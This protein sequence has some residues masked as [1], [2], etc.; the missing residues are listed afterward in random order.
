MRKRRVLVRVCGHR[1]RKPQ[2]KRPRGRNLAII[3]AISMQN[4]HLHPPHGGGGWGAGFSLEFFLFFA[5]KYMPATGHGTCSPGRALC[6]KVKRPWGRNLAIMRSA[7]R[8]NEREMPR[9]GRPQG[10]FVSKILLELSHGILSLFELGLRLTHPRLH[11]EVQ[12]GINIKTSNN[13]LASTVAGLAA[14]SATSSS[15]MARS[16]AAGNADRRPRR[17][18]LGTQSS[19]SALFFWPSA[20]NAFCKAHTTGM[21]NLPGRDRRN[22]SRTWPGDT[23]VFLSTLPRWYSAANSA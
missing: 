12:A 18:R 16:P 4:A 13:K 6:A 19:S 1:A 2:V 20:M 3:V 9:F 22:C 10:T 23:V 21:Q 14:A 7:H 15:S 8:E 17:A 5:K 11:F